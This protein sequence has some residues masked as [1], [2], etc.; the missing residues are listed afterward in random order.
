MRIPA[1]I[2]TS[3]AS[4]VPHSATAHHASLALEASESGLP[5]T[6]SV[7]ITATVTICNAH[8]NSWRSK[9]I[10]LGASVATASTQG[11][12]ATS[13]SASNR[14]RHARRKRRNRPGQPAPWFELAT[15]GCAA[16]DCPREV[17][18]RGG[19]EVCGKPRGV[20]REGVHLGAQICSSDDN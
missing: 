13:I 11:S 2:T 20:L 7:A 4:T 19:A 18:R 1:I 15:C 16:T 10:Q 17:V 8:G 6:L 5:T 9:R 14:R 3:L 12:R